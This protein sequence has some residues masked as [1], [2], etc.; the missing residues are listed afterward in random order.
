MNLFL[1][2]KGYFFILIK[3][4]FLTFLPLFSIK[5]AI[6][7]LLFFAGI[8]WIKFLITL[9]PLLFAVAFFTV[10]ERKFMGGTQ[11]R[12]GPTAVGVFGSLQAFADAIKLLAKETIIPSASNSVIFALAPVSTFLFSV[13][14]WAVVPMHNLS[15]FADVNIAIFFILSSSSLG[16]Y[17]II[18]AGWSSNSKYAFLGGLRSAA[19][20]ISYE[21][22]LGLIMMPI[23]FY[24][25]SFNYL[26]LLRLKWIFIFYFHF[27]HLLFY[28]LFL[29]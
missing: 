26:L 1:N 19:Q 7:A 14:A 20:L 21:V 4:F 8:D 28:F 29:Y 17:G 16:A 5:I 2:F 11:R 6:I 3:W 15:V 13:F 24:S 12:R 9:L 25:T 10:Y 18:M 23:F 27:F 22:S